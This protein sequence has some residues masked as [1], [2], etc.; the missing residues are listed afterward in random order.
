ME[1]Y[2][3]TQLPGASCTSLTPKMLIAM[4]SQEV[5]LHRKPLLPIAEYT[6]PL[7]VGEQVFQIEQRLYVHICATFIHILDSIV[8]FG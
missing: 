4:I 7:Q 6:Y 1:S 2:V 8:D 5:A 3:T